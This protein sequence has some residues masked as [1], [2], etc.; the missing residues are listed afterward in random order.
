LAEVGYSTVKVFYHRFIDA[1]FTLLNIQQMLRLNDSSWVSAEVAAPRT[2]SAYGGFI[3]QWAGAIAWLSNKGQLSV[4]T[5]SKAFWT[6][7]Y[8]H[9]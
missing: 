6:I 9:H 8:R 2:T 5:A 4:E 7:N 1:Y 3:A